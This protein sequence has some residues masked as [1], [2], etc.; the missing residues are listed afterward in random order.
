VEN[1]ALSGLTSIVIVAADSGED[2]RR[3][4]DAALASSAT[5]EILISDNASTDGSVDAIAAKF[6][7]DERVRILSNGANLGFGAGCNRADALA[8]GDVV[9]FLNPDCRIETDTVTRLRACLENDR[10][11]GLLGARILGEDGA[12][13]PASRRRDPLLRRAL[14]SLS[15][16]ARFE[17]RWPGLAGTNMRWPP[18]AEIEYVEAV[19]GALLLLPRA[20]F[21][22]LGGFDEGYFLHCEDLDLCRRVRDAGLQVACANAVAVTHVKGT[23]GRRRPFFVAWHKHRGMWRWF[24]KYDPAARNTLLR[25]I[26]WCGVW[27][28][29]VVLAPRY[30]WALLRAR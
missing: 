30:A 13:E 18:S 19:S 14:S 29:Y 16:L 15:G 8:N 11:I 1:A 27:L 7:H 24:A 3:C 25:A 10:T 21:A 9:L 5:V 26:V 12:L 23:S 22:R 17:L 4:V 6:A 2:L 28:H 20:L